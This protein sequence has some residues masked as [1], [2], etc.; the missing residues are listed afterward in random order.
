MPTGPGRYLIEDESEDLEARLRR[1][2]DASV[3]AVT[4]LTHGRT[5]VRIAGQKA[6]W[7]LATGIAIDFDLSAFPVGEVRLTHHHEIGLTI[8]RTAKDVFELYV[9]T[10][11]ARAFW[12]WITTASQEIGYSAS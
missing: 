3:G 1:E 8:H 5:V 9:F 11:F 2:I 4:G 10:S 6:S 7:V 12:T